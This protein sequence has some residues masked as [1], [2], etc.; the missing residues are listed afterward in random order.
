MGAGYRM[1]LQKE[2]PVLRKKGKDE[3][4]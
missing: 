4:N 3:K 2:E 1:N